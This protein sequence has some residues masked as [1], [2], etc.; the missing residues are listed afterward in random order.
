MGR[1]PTPLRGVVERHPRGKEAIQTLTRSNTKDP[2]RDRSMSVKLDADRYRRL[3]RAR[4]EIEKSGQEIFV[5]AL[6][7]WLSD[8]KY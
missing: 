3:A 1:K 7:L 2:G 5:E 6:D 4:F 8:H